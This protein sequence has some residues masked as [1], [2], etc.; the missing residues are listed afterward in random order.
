M[1]ESR[2]WT[3]YDRP[4]LRAG[5]G[6]TVGSSC[7]V[8][9]ALDGMHCAACASRAT[10]QL[11]GQA[12]DIH[13]N[14][15]ARTARFRFDPR[16]TRLSA[17]L[18]ALDGA[19]LD[20][21]ILASEN[22]AERDKKARRM[23]FARIGVATICAM[24]VMMLAWPTYFVADID[25]GTKALLRGAQLVLSIPGVLWA[26]WPFFANAW[27]AIRSRR[28]DMDVPVALA[29]S[30]AF[31][32]STVRVLLGSGELYFDTATMFVWFLTV[33]RYLE[34][35]SRAR[36]S[37]RLRLLAGRRALTAQR[38]IN[39]QVETIPIGQLTLGDVAV[40]APGDT[41]P[42]DGTLLERAAELDEA[43]LSGESR[44][45]LRQPGQTL[46]AGTL[47]L[48]S[49][50]LLLKVERLGANTVL[51]QITQLLDHGE[52]RKP[53]L[54]QF[55]D[56]IAGHFIAAVLALAAIGAA[57]ALFRGASGDV[58][59]G[60]ALAVLVASCPCALSLA[61]PVALAA[62][63]SRLARGGVLVANASALQPLATIDHVLFDKTGTLTDNR[64]QLIQILPLAGGDSAT[65]V[66]I[67]AALERGSRHPL[68]SAFADIAT[69]LQAGQ[70]TH[71]AGSGISGI[72]AGQR[73]R[74]GALDAAPVPVGLPPGF[75]SPADATVIALSDDQQPLALFVIGAR[76]RAEATA[77]AAELRR[78]GLRLELLSGDAEDAVHAVAQAVG[79]DDWR[80]RQTPAAKLARLQALR[81]D[82][83]RLLAVGDGLNDA[84]LLAAADV[85]ACMPQGAALT[86]SKADLL[87]LGDTLSLLP[88]TLDVARATQARIR[89][90]LWWALGYNLLVLPLAM[91][92]T[93]PPWLAAAGM[94]ASSLLV[95]GNALRLERLPSPPSLAS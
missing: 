10:K 61:V 67:A 58:A 3:V 24:Q 39:G 41:V 81:A 43:L 92:G 25:A 8:M 21:R 42:A 62:A 73:Y 86:Q 32:A 56:R 74:L 13:I 54:Q 76:L 84:P 83:H 95:V 30:T 71:V 20:P 82:G 89:E 23:A 7:E 17:L 51:A 79:I 57:L 44:P 47:N 26:G 64:M 80:A 70:L 14:V 87:L 33:G 36:A 5:F 53:K 63:T 72:I 68:A 69:P 19:G 18:A 2:D 77:V 38:R 88:L 31:A 60:I 29:L 1:N 15:A 28:L 93:L 75:A 27:R 49:A 6:T 85:S 50:P 22:S 66:R 78:R 34:G 90:N 40:V 45:Q 11:S 35:R 12:S 94:S 16:T 48:G 4:D 59:F 55:A 91:S 9:L 46:L 37:E 52:T 65:L